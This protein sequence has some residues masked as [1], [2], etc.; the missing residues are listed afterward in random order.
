MIIRPLR[1]SEPTDFPPSEAESFVS[2]GR[3][4]IWL[5]MVAGVAADDPVFVDHDYQGTA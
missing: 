3:F 5:Q 1:A 2:W 4:G